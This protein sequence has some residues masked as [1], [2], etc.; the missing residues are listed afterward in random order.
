MKAKEAQELAHRQ[1]EK[2][3]FEH[4][5]TPFETF[6]SINFNIP[7]SQFVDQETIAKLNLELDPQSRLGRVAVAAAIMEQYHPAFPLSLGEV[8]DDYLKDLMFIK[9]SNQPNMADDPTFMQ[10]LL[11]YEEPH[12][13]V[14]IG[15]IQFEPLS[16]EFGAPIIHPRVEIFP[17]WPAIAASVTVSMAQFEKDPKRRL[18][19]LEQA[20]KTCPG[21]TLVRENTAELLELLG[22]LTG[23]IEAVRWSLERRPCARTLYV[24]YLLTGDKQCY[25]KLVRTYTD[26]IIQYF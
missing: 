8:W 26:K 23:A 3:E 7:R 19:I 13:V 9:L 4:G 15:D 16:L 25:D 11:M 6:Y 2:I 5:P 12:A 20:E 1:A 21:L 14:I 22:D 10:E 17:L 24:M 18:L